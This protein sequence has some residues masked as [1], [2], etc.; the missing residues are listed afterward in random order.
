VGLIRTQ[1]RELSFSCPFTPNFL[2]LCLSV[3]CLLPLLPYLTPSLSSSLSLTALTLFL[4]ILFLFLG[5]EII[6]AGILDPEILHRVKCWVEDANGRRDFSHVLNV[7]LRKWE[8]KKK[9]ELKS[10]AEEQSKNGK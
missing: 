8:M 10:V 6:P 5:H 4:F 9:A 7:E 2:P 3:F 1:T